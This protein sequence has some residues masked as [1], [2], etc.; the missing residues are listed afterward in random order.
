M[1]QLP[2]PWESRSGAPTRSRKWTNRNTEVGPTITQKA[3]PFHTLELEEAQV[4]PSPT[5]HQYRSTTASL[6]FKNICWTGGRRERPCSASKTSASG[7]RNMG[8]GPGSLPTHVWRAEPAC[9]PARSSHD[10]RVGFLD[11]LVDHDRDPSTT[12]ATGNVGQARASACV[13]PSLE[14]LSSL[15]SACRVACSIYLI[16]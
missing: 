6:A 9:W 5:D 16:G 12:H 4:P 2:F 1:G 7:R 10:S 8:G 13:V 3:V 15:I 11:Y 14:S